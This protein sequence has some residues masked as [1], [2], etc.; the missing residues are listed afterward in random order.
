MSYHIHTTEAFVITSSPRGERNSSLLLLTEEMG[1]LYA[2]AQ[3]VRVLQSKLRSHLVP[4]ALTRISLIRGKVEWRVVGAESLVRLDR[5]PATPR[6][7]LLRVLSLAA[8][9]TLP[10]DPHTN[11]F[12]LMREA[13]SVLITLPEASVPALELL[14]VLKIIAHA[15]FLP[16]DAELTP[17]LTAPLTLT[18]AQNFKPLLQHGLSIANRSLE[19]MQ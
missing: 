3:G 15:G 19:R 18:S 6:A 10:D 4:H 12:P 1:T 9:T 16:D 13:M 17:Y 2:H 14:T 7:A 5:F 8:H 11:H